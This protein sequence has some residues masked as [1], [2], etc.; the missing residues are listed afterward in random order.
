MTTTEGVQSEIT[1]S[2][3]AITAIQQ[4][5]ITL[6]IASDSIVEGLFAFTSSIISISALASELENVL[7]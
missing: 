1:T 4:E 2:T 6:G 7:N 5:L 3:V